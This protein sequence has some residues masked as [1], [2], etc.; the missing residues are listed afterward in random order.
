MIYLKDATKEISDIIEKYMPELKRKYR[1]V[2]YS[3]SDEGLSLTCTSDNRDSIKLQVKPDDSRRIIDIPQSNREY[4]KQG[5]HKA[6]FKQFDRHNPDAWKIE[7]KM[8]FSGSTSEI[9]FSGSENNWNA[10][11]FEKNFVDN[12]SRFL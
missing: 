4:Q 2:D 11:D 1:Q 8:T 3:N 9:A 12:F 5:G 7:L 10:S 6:L